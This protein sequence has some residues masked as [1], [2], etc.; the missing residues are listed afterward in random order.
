MKTSLDARLGAI[1][2]VR[3]AGDGKLP[4]DLASQIDTLL[5]RA[6]QRRKRSPE[7]TVVGLFGATGSGKS[8]LLNALV[9][10]DVAV[11]H[12]RRPTTSQ[13]LAVTWDAE[14]AVD[15]LDWLEVRDRV[16]RETPLDAR[17]R[18][19]VLLDLPDFDS[20][21]LGNREI[22]ERLAAQVDAIVWVV[23]PQKYADQVLHAQFIEPHSR[24]GAVTLVVL[25]Q[26]DLLPVDQVQSV[27]VSLQ[28]LLERDGLGRSRVHAVSARTGAGIPELRTAIGDLSAAKAALEARLSADVATV[29]DRIPVAGASRAPSPKTISA[30][31]EQLGTAAGVDV[32]ANAVAGSY[33]KRAGQAT[34][35]PLVSWLLRL[36]ADPLTRLGLGPARRTGTPELHRTSLPSPNAA[37]SA[38]A[39]LAVRGF[40]DDAARELSEPWKAG[41]RAAADR[42]I[43]ELPGELDLAISRTKLPAGRS[44]WWPIFSVLQW[45][46]ILG[47]LVGVG[48]LLAAAFFPTVGLPRPEIPMVE[49]WAVPTLLVI[50]GALLGML[51]GL[52]GAVLA[53]ATAASRRRRSRKVLLAEIGA[54]TARVVVAPVTSELDLA[55]D[56]DAAR[57][58]AT[59]AK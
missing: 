57:A 50:A 32:V 55:R 22:A 54:V 52:V 5:G 43:A 49:G 23:D 4:A 58:V 12:V 21:E 7:H 13:P 31:T 53:A 26:A 24:H 51:L 37:A 28:A 48:W 35:W 40:A 18:Q 14:G 15:L 41:I 3:S 56:F 46:A 38:R 45:V 17:A 19:L 47:A 42:T 16:V 34:G 25:N 30:L 11:T 8:S 36:R 2:T 20:V 27:L 59:A 29:A 10:A 9:G 1:A 6:T 44:W 33:R 39:S